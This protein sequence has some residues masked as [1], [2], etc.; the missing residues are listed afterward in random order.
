MMRNLGC[1]AS[2]YKDKFNVGFMD[3]RASEK[4]FE[5]YDVKLDYGKTTPA[6]IIFDN[7]KAYPALP[8]TLSA[9]KLDEFIKG[10]IEGVCQY[11]PQETVLA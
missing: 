1:V 5:S 8:S 9:I 2:V 3:H 6:L 11:C 7:G 4:V 10:Y